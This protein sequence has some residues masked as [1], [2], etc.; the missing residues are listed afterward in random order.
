[1]V[2]SMPNIRHANSGVFILVGGGESS[3]R[4]IASLVAQLIGVKLYTCRTQSEAMAIL[5][6]ADPSLANL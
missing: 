5:A 3:L 4:F 2:S 1:M 6:K